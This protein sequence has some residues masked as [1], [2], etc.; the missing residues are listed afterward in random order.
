MDAVKVKRERLRGPSEKLK[1]FDMLPLSRAIKKAVEALE[2]E[3]ATP[4]QAKTIAPALAGRDICGSAVT[5]SGKTAA[6][7]LPVLERIVQGSSR[8]SMATRVLILLPTRELAV[9]C[10][11]V[12][13]SLSRF[14]SIT[15]GLSVGGLSN[16]AQEAVIRARPDILVATPGRLIDHI[17]NAQGFS[18]DNIEILIL[19]EAD[20]LLEMGFRDEVEEIVRLCPAA[21][22]TLLFSATMS[23]QVQWLVKLSLRNP[24]K[25]AVDP[26]FDVAETLTQEFVRLREK[27]ETNRDA[28]LLA[29]VTRN[30]RTKTI[31]FFAQKHVAH[32]FRV[33]FGLAGLSAGE[34]HGNLT[35]A[36]RLTALQD[37]RDGRIDF[38]LCTDLAARGLDIIGVHT[39]INYEMP[40]TLTEYVHRVGRTAR[41]G[42]QGVA[43]SIVGEKE[44]KLLREIYKKARDQLSS[45]KIAVKVL[46]VWRKKIDRF[47]NDIEA[48]LKEER[49]EK[50]IRTADEEIKRA[51]NL[52][53]HQAE[54]MSRPK[55]TWFQSQ[56]AR[57]ETK[58]KARE[59]ATGRIEEEPPK[60]RTRTDRKKEK[61]A[62][63]RER[64][65]QEQ[66]KIVD[67][68]R[69]LAKMLAKR[70]R[71]QQQKK[72]RDRDNAPAVQLLASGSKKRRRQ[73][74]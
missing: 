57:K 71:K 67:R 73:P 35:Q 49:R 8:K 20:R 51:E 45:R 53:N 25:V 44:R 7:V 38:L 32:R 28:T 11:A 10:Q 26:K 66:R 41:A 63:S 52:L 23:S 19:D 72:L 5:G 22:Q 34:L 62:K 18:L 2:W 6:F 56:D 46:D 48:I 4:I 3:H 54:I 15:T 58:K 69:T 17:R 40:R 70:A 36:Q 29:L 60:K 33:L 74:A 68:E 13:T 61:F 47:H 65:M 12:V 30:F 39:V 59:Q 37:F 14:T 16:R 1:S 21:R 24:L 42:K 31:I 43:V 27:T 64:S 55:R 50:E 9:Q